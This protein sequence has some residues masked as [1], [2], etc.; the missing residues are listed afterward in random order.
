M[1]EGLGGN[2][3]PEEKKAGLNL[4]NPLVKSAISVIAGVSILIILTNL[5]SNLLGKKVWGD[6]WFSIAI[7]SLALRFILKLLGSTEFDSPLKTIAIIAS[8]M[9][10]IN[11]VRPN[12]NVKTVASTTKPSIVTGL[13][14][15]ISPMTFE[16]KTYEQDWFRVYEG[17]VVR[18][19]SPQG[20]WVQGEDGN[21][22]YNNPSYSNKWMEYTVTSTKKGGELIKIWGDDTFQI[23]F[24]VRSKA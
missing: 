15:D 14:R 1:A 16:V 22:Y 24:N 2:T 7:I 18:Y 6:I 3:L 17:D 5:T 4:S 19:L 8:V 11:T 9:L 21:K 13:P 20:F 10:F 12:T 23:K